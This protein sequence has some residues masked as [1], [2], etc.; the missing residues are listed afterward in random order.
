MA[1]KVFTASDGTVFENREEYK[2]YEFDLSYTFQGKT[3][4]GK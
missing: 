2:K 4:L 1:P 3:V